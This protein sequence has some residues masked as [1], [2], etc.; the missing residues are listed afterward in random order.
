M[1]KFTQLMLTLAL[2]VV[3]VGGV[4]AIKYYDV[5]TRYTSV[6]ALSGKYFAI[7]D[8]TA[9]K[10][11]YTKSGNNFSFGSYTDAFNPSNGAIY[12]KLVSLAED[13][14]VSVRPYYYIV[15]VTPSGEEYI[16]YGSTGY[17]NSQ[18]DGGYCCFVQYNYSSD[19]VRH[20]GQDIDYGAVWDVQ[21][22]A[23][24]GGFSI[25]N[26]G[27]GK[28]LKDA[29]PAKYADAT[30]FTF[31]SIKE[32]W[33][34][35]AVDPIAET[36]FTTLGTYTYENGNLTA[37]LSAENGLTIENGTAR[38]YWEAHFDVTPSGLPT[39]IG[40]DYVLFITIKGASDVNVNCNMGTYPDL[41]DAICPVTTSFVTTEVMFANVSAASSRTTFLS[42]NIT[43]DIYVKDAAVYEMV[44]AKHIEIDD[45]GF[46]TFSADKAVNLRG[47]T[48]YKAKYEGGYVKLTPVTEVP[49]DN[50]VIIEGT[51][52]EYELP[53][54]DDA[55]ALSEN[56]L[57][58]SNGSVT[59][60]GSTIYALGKKG[61]VV[62]FAKVKNGAT[63]PAGKAYLIIGGGSARDFIGFGEEEA[64]GISLTENSE[65]RTENAVYDL[66][67]RRVAQPTKGLY[68]VNGK[69]VLVK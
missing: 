52:G 23:G 45:A 67:G 5:D 11:F 69:K 18:P 4:K 26:I 19:P 37:S 63:V 30:Y 42:G 33:M 61:G 49:A 39:T 55:S 6:G 53:T 56:D 25:K 59:G 8:E 7:V 65:L 15:A 43:S 22:S 3:G 35:Y 29:A 1:R 14:D 13:E 20:H 38:G 51:K 50:G 41:V 58:V 54:I 34:T 57:R 62:G 66:Q 28:Y 68:I 12:F 24:G 44:E 46:A 16:V 36:D 9:A 40:K 48:G 64:T 32:K 60:D 21:Y 27:T 2:L 10:A 17:L 47:V 31:C